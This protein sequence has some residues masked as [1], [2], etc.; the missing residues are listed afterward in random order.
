[1]LNIDSMADG[2]FSVRIDWEPINLDVFIN[3]TMGIPK[4]EFMVDARLTF[5]LVY[6]TNYEQAVRFA[7]VA[8]PERI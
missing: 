8:A 3:D 2:R 4:E 7:L 5:H 1:M 6:F